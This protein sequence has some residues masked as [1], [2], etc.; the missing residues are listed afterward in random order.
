[1]GANKIAYILN[2]GIAPYFQEELKGQLVKSDCFVSSF[3]ESL[4]DVTQICQ[5]DLMV[6]YWD[7]N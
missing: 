3:D 2:F 4:N 5:M 7:I 1:M 6:R